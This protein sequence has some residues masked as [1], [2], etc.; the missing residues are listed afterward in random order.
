MTLET[1]CDDFLGGGLKILQPQAGYRAGIDPVL[2][3][4]SI[5]AKPGE[6]VL[7]LGCGVGVAGLCLARRVPGVH[8]VGLERQPAYA[9][10]A[11]QN[12]AANALPFEVVEGDLSAM[13][14]TLK[15]RQ[16]HHVLAN[17]PYFD[18][19]ASTAATDPGREG[20]MGE[21]TPLAAWVAAAAK[22]TGPKGTT[23]F[24]QRA[25][26]LPELLSHAARHL[27]SLQLLPLIPR[28]GRLARLVLLRGRRGG[29]AAFRLHDGWCLHNGQRHVNDCENYTSATACILRDGKEMPFPD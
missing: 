22:R 28:P 16:F 3:A 25:D 2:L 4:A 29:R 19:A 11:R 5:P 24:I 9:E 17:P 26:R 20:A 27:G 1:T 6:T 7:D 18:R 12:G 10:L 13:P 8:L 21:D 15:K 14:D 23:T